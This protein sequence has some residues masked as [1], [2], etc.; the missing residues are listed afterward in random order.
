MTWYTNKLADKLN[1]A[2]PSQSRKDYRPEFATK[3]N[4][5]FYVERFGSERKIMTKS[6]RK[7]CLL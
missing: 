2:A 7:T 4:E 1:D 3:L 6:T 5:S